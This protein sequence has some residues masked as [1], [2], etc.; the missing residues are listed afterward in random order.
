MPNN[1]V[2]SLDDFLINYPEFD[3]SI[4]T[5]YLPIAF[6]QAFNYVNLRYKCFDEETK[7]AVI[8][9]LTAHLSVL[10]VQAVNNSAQGGQGGLVA[11]ASVGEVS[12]SYTTIPNQ[13]NI[14]YWLSLTPY[15]LELLA[16]L[17]DLMPVCRYIGGS[18]E[19][20]F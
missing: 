3:N 20:V 4:Y 15:G 8:Y 19:R 11:S 13:D 6:R 14:S 1:I 12:V 2:I 10:K 5:S 7:R 18:L 17:E 16:L 9:L